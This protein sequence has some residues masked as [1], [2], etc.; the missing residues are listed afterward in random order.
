MQLSGRTRESLANYQ[1]ALAISKTLHDRRGQAQALLNLG[2]TYADLAQV[3][4]SL[5]SYE[6]ALELWRDVGDRGGQAR[7]LAGL[8]QLHAVAGEN[9]LALGRYRE[10]TAHSNCSVTALASRSR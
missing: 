8:G 2:Y 10:A 1:D 3:S 7:T 6:A 9:Q 4:D 5:A